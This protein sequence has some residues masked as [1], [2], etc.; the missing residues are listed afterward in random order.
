MV[1]RTGTLRLGDLKHE[2]P[3]LLKRLANDSVFWVIKVMT[4]LRCVAC[5]HGV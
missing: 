5:F 1:T 2:T 4:V 3:S